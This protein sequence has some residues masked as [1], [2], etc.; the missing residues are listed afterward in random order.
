MYE[1][2]RLTLSDLIGKRTTKHEA[3][4]KEKVSEVEKGG[5]SV[6]RLS[7]RLS[8][9]LGKG[10]KS[11]KVVDKEDV[12]IYHA[13][14]LA[15]FKQLQDSLPS[16]RTK[17][18]K[19]SDLLERDRLESEIRA[20][21]DREEETEYLLQTFEIVNEYMS[22]SS[23]EGDL[24]SDDSF[25][26]SSIVKRRDNRLQQKLAD[27]YYRVVDPTKVNVKNLV[28]NSENC[29]ECGAVLFLNNGSYS[30]SQC[31][32]VSCKAVSE[33]QFSYK[34]MQ[35]MQMKTSFAYQKLNRF[36]EILHAMQG[37]G[38]A[39][40]PDSVVNAVR[41]EIEKDRMSLGN[42]DIHKVRYYL[43]QIG[44]SM[45][46][47]HSPYIILRLTGKAPMTLSPELEQQLISMFVKVQEH[48]P[49]A[50]QLVA[51]NRSSSPSYMY[52]FY[53]FFELLD[54]P[55]EM[56]LFPLLKSTEKVRTHDQIWKII[57]ERLNWTYYSSL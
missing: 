49:E 36:K 12:E 15:Y 10:A 11:K 44:K 6:F 26:L 22:A 24:V 29:D 16:K 17:L 21:E 25:S 46:Y 42:V 3:R 37:K 7:N 5:P 2:S 34:D 14:Q 19:C 35:D 41:K 27:D 1:S 50:K 4:T 45:H 52:M 18:A 53:K 28:I 33:F 51:P 8:S 9:I 40:V 54:M 13:K 47:E 38:N 39:D 30:C 31:G 20:I 57:C 56:K 32:L 23:N 43:K 48:L 55:K